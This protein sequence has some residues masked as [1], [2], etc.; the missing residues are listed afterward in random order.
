[1]AV[2]GWTR[3]GKAGHEFILL[4]L[5]LI[6]MGTALSDAKLS[7][8]EGKSIT[9]CAIRRTV[10]GR[11]MGGEGCREMRISLQERTLYL[12]GL[13]LLIRKDRRIHDKEKDMMMRVGEILGFDR[14]FCESTINGLIDNK[15]IIDMPPQFSELR[16]AQCF[17]RDGLSLG[18][19]DGELDE[20]EFA[21]LRTVADKNGI[22]DRWYE[23]AAEAASNKALDSRAGDTLETKR[24]EWE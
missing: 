20:E 6:W 1:M 11:T 8:I 18:C 5:F 2:Y 14:K 21:W 13:M 24:L 4:I 10:L 23:T 22:D 9:Q 12:K 7:K 19:T 17:I 15:H 3:E 16:I